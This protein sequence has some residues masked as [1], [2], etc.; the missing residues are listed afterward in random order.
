[1]CF[2]DLWLA[3]LVA[4]AAV[5][6]ASSLV[7]M[8]LPF[9]KGDYQVPPAPDEFGAPLAKH[10]PP[11]GRYMIGWCG[12]G[13]AEKAPPDPSAPRGLLVVQY[14]PVSMG[15]TL[16][17]WA[18]HLL[19]VSVLIAYAASLA[20]GPGAAGMSVFRVTSAVAL[21]AYGAGAAPRAIWEGLPWKQ[22]PTA[23]LDALI[24]AAATG[25]VFAWLWPA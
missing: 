6:V 7:W 19:V 11:V 2:C 18:L 1:M 23:L 20:L 8:V 24:Y 15:R 10:R 17:I 13:G 5:F 9:H 4:T 12:P 21:L 25:A 22:V 3:I 16:G 14:G